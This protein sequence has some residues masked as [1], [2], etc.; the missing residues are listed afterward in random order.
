MAV[1]STCSRR[2]TCAPIGRA[3][4]PRIV[5]YTTRSTSDSSSTKAGPRSGAR[6]IR[7]VNTLSMEKNYNTGGVVAAESGKDARKV[8]VMLYHDKTRP[9]ALYVPIA[10]VS[11]VEEPKEKRKK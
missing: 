1:P 8:T 11:S 7:P 4:V 6:A 5:M 9:S 2:A 10:A 3:L